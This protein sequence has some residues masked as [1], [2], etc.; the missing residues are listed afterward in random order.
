MGEVYQ[1]CLKISEIIGK[2]LTI[3]DIQRLDKLISDVPVVKLPEIF[4]LLIEPTPPDAVSAIE[5][6]ELLN[7][8][9][10]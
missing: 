3:N 5:Q 9:N 2:D 8:K 1:L 7:A 6:W 4:K 10:E